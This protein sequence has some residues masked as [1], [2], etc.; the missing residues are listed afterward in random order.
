MQLASARSESCPPGSLRDTRRLHQQAMARLSA[1]PGPP[2]LRDYIKATI[3]FR[4]KVLVFR[5]HMR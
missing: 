3:G 4:D 5:P 2:S 1:E